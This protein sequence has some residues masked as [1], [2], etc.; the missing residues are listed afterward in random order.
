MGKWAAR[1]AEKAAAPIW[2]GT[3]TTDKRGVLAVLAVT[4]QGGT[5]DFQVA[6]VPAAGFPE[7]I[8]LAAEAWTG[9]DI[10]RF[11]DRRARLARW[12]WADNEAETLAERLV[13]RDRGRDDRV[14]CI[15][16]RHR[17]PG[18]CGNHEAATLQS[19]E[20]GRDF[21]AML[22]RCAGFEEMSP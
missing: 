10:A 2:V 6:L 20:V 1:L 19:P 8:D 9:A 14:S 5:H 12:G 4:P 21:A 13:K 18:R 3:D 22:Q 7:S 15:D 16:C 17:R 11:H